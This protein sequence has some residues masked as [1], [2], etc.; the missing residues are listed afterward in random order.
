MKN[1]KELKVI[2]HNPPTKEEADKMID[3]LCE[4]LKE[5]E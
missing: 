2:V 3:E 1:R 5:M 4:M